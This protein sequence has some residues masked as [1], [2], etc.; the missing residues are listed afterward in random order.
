MWSVTI[1]VSFV[2]GRINLRLCFNR[3]VAAKLIV[4]SE[5]KGKTPRPHSDRKELTL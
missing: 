2:A 4:S 5:F 1:V 3:P